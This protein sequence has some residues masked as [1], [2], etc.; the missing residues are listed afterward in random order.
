MTDPTKPPMFGPSTTID[1][2]TYEPCA[3][4]S[5]LMNDLTAGYLAAGGRSAVVDKSCS[6]DAHVERRMRAGRK[7]DDLTVPAPKAAPYWRRF[8]KRKF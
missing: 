7:R 6:F 8:D 3:G 1:F 5:S 4:K 2:A